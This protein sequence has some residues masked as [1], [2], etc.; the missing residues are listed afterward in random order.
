MMGCSSHES[1]SPMW[2]EV[3]DAGSG[4]RSRAPRWHLTIPLTLWLLVIAGNWTLSSTML[5]SW[6]TRLGEMKAASWWPSGVGTSLPPLAMELPS[7]R[8]PL[9]RGRLTWPCSSLWVMVRPWLT[10]YCWGTWDLLF[11]N[12]LSGGYGVCS[13]KV[14]IECLSH[15]TMI[16]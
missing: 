8:A 3:C 1:S 7:R 2:K 16:L 11:L 14:F 4:L 15:D 10:P 6:I 9:G 12:W 13:L 5:R